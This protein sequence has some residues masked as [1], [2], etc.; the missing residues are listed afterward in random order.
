MLDDFALHPLSKHVPQL[1]EETDRA[2]D[3][4]GHLLGRGAGW[5]LLDNVPPIAGKHGDGR[6]KCVQCRA[7]IENFLDIGAVRDSNR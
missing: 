3:A 2:I 7:R 6:S 5:Q 1:L 4:N